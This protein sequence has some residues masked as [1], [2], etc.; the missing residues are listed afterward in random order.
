[1]SL[2]PG[3]LIATPKLNGSYFGGTVILLLSHDDDGAFGLVLNHETDAIGPDSILRLLDIDDPLVMP[4][5]LSGGPVQP[6][7]AFLLHGGELTGEETLEAGDG[8]LVSSKKET[9]AKLCQDSDRPF[10]LVLG[11]AGWY[12]GQ[13]EAEIEDGSWLATALED[14]GQWVLNAERDRLWQDITAAMGLD[15]WDHLSFPA[16]QTEVQ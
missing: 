1:V 12:Q 15:D 14:R 3:F 10:W 7:R 6:E 11:Y 16:A 8:I 5:L 9:L 4:G 2:A 13:L